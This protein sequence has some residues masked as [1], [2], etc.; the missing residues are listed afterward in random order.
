MEKIKLNSKG[1]N[2][3]IKANIL[4][5]AKM[6][7]NG[8]SDFSKTNWYFCKTVGKDITLNI[9]IPKNGSDIEIITL[10]EDF[11]QPYDYQ[12]LLEK[13][14]KFEFALKIKE[15]VEKYM[16]ELKNAGILSGHEYGEYI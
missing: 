6:R 15:Q 13:D 14:P 11:C 8:F 2:T 16:Q 4:D 5:D 7:E 3:N 9:T 12:R 1:T 10:D